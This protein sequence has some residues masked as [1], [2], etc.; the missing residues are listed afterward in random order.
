MQGSGIV[1][2]LLISLENRWAPQGGSVPWRV[3][4]FDAPNGAR[5]RVRILRRFFVEE[6]R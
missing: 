6:A 5:T 3:G 1:T 4:G 2:W